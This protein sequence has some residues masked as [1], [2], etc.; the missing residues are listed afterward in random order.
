VPRPRQS[1]SESGSGLSD[2]ELLGRYVHFQDEAAFELLLWRHGALVLNVCRRVLHCEQDAEDAFQATFLTF[3][4]QAHA[5]IRRGSVASWLYKV[6]YRVALEAKAQARKT[7]AHEKRGG[8]SRAIQSPPDPTWG[9]LRPILDE[10]LNRLPERLCRPIV[11]CYLEGKTNEE[12]ARQLGCPPGTIFSRLARGREMLRNRLLRRGL[13]LSTAALTAELAEH[14]AEAVPTA[15]LMAATLRAALAFATGSAVASGS[16]QVTA[17]AE[18]VLKTMFVTKLKMAALA[19]FVVGI[20]AAGGVLTRHALTATPQPE[21]RKEPQSV[22]PKPA[23][24]AEDKK[25]AVRVAQPM[26]G[27]LNLRR[28]GRVRAAA[29]QQ[30]YAAISGYLKEQPVDI[31]SIV[32]KGDILAVIDAPLL[33]VEAK[34]AEAA[35][36]LENGRFQEAQARVVTA[37]AELKAAE[38]RTRAAQSKLKSDRAYLKFREKQAQRYAALLADRAVDEKVVAEQEDRREAALEAVNASVEAVANVQADVAVKR[39]KIDSAKAALESAKASL[40]M[41]RCAVEK[42]QIQLGYRRIVA[43]FDGVVTQR[44][45]DVGDYIAASD[46]GTRRPLLTVQRTDLVRVVA[47][48][49]E[50]QLPRTRPGVAVDLESDALPGVQF[51]GQKI[52]RIGFAVDE[53]TSTMPVEI[54]VPNPKGLLRPGMSISVALHLK[55]SLPNVFTVPLSCLGGSKGLFVREGL[56]VYIVRDGK[57]HLTPVRDGLRN[58]NTVEILSG[59]QATDRIVLDPKDLSGEVVPIEIQKEP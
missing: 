39:S 15:P 6:A 33:L 29:Q 56:F 13:T 34:Q 35:L 43:A 25:I 22:Q 14:A 26:P 11:L 47:D 49:A 57:A 10:E 21:A 41:A 20:L 16:T 38:G 19:L 8:D 52:A 58:R 1:L 24:K 54:D 45:F 40:V 36:A 44:S 9:E 3:V 32:K 55:K 2:A 4:R 7:A 59:L 27:G 17:L 30:V 31:G 50:A 48:V 12:A 28:A 23:Q 51:F 46:H 53:K 42:A 37:Q 18:G 5:I